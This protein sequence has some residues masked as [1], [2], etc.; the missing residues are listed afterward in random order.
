[1]PTSAVCPDSATV[2]FDNG[3]ADGETHTAALRF[4]GK[5]CIENLLRLARRK[6]GAGV[7]D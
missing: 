4:R 3:F 1:M 6:S 7:A 2:R 5:E